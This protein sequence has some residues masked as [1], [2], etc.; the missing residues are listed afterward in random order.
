MI[1]ETRHC[2][3]QFLICTN[4]KKHYVSLYKTI[5]ITLSVKYACAVCIVY[6]RPVP[7]SSGHCA[8]FSIVVLLPAYILGPN[9]LLI[10]SF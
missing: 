1:T 7:Y 10:T 8:I 4:N 2:F 6:L 5:S 9:I 3:V